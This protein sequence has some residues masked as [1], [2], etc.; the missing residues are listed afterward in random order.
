MS[1]AGDAGE[2]GFRICT[3]DGASSRSE[4]PIWK[5]SL[6]CGG[7]FDS[8]TALIL[9]GDLDFASGLDQLPGRSICSKDLP[10]KDRITVAPE[11]EGILSLLFRSC[12]VH[13]RH[14]A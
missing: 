13:Q 5:R 12:R 2:R 8:W 1:L 14:C 10:E 3:R 9:F 4:I 11:H 7:C 6:L